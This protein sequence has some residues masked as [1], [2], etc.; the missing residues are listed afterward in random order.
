MF[1][2][3][4]HQGGKR[5]KRPHCAGKRGDPYRFLLRGLGLSPAGGVWEDVAQAFPAEARQLGRSSPRG[6]TRQHRP[7]KSLGGTGVCSTG[8]VQGREGTG[9]GS[10]SVCCRDCFSDFLG[11]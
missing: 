5:E 2:R 4:S 10:A 1:L 3:L 9:V 11:G 7:R 8:R 6:L